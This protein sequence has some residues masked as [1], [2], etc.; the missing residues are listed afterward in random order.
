MSGASLSRCKWSM[1]G[2]ALA[3]LMIINVPL[4][5]QDGAQTA[6]PTIGRVIT[7]F[8]PLPPGSWTR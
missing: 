7:P 5:A 3:A 8:F 1:I 4:C 6:S 2:F